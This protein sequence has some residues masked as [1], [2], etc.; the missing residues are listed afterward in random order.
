MSGKV[1][2]WSGIPSPFKSQAYVLILL[3][4]ALLFGPADN[5]TFLD[6]LNTGFVFFIVVFAAGFFVVL[7]GVLY[8]LPVVISTSGANTCLI[9]TS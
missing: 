2:V 3:F 5:T 4:G 1:L 8:V 6:T 7:L 9:I